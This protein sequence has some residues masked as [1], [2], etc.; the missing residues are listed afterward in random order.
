M[1]PQNKLYEA[2]KN[3]WK[4]A[5]KINARANGLSVLVLDE[6]FCALMRSIHKLSTAS[7]AYE[8]EQPEAIA[9]EKTTY[10]TALDYLSEMGY[11]SGTN[12]TSKGVASLL[13][14]FASQQT[15]AKDK[16]IEIQQAHIDDQDQLIFDQT[17]EI[18][19]LK[20]NINRLIDA[21]MDAYTQHICKHEPSLD[22]LAETVLREYVEFEDVNGSKTVN[23]LPLTI[24]D[25]MIEFVDRIYEDGSG[26]TPEE[27]AEKRWKE[28]QC[29]F[30]IAD[31]IE[32]VHFYYHQTAS[33][34][35]QIEELKA[36]LSDLI[37][38]KDWK[39]KYGEDERYLQALP[40]ALKNAKKLIQK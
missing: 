38:V 20:E 14:D 33:K 10:E 40:V 12:F 24:V 39:E 19:D 11:G 9:G 3:V 23:L 4:V 13:A 18:A 29:E 17:K 26:I 31:F 22:K 7:S 34:D 35:K 37:H 21:H 6:D 8:Q 36:A 30:S 16:E 32:G 15:S 25:M 2:A 28:S 1:T 27:F 5:D